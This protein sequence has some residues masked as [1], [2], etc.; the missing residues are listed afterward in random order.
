LLLTVSAEGRLRLNLP[1]GTRRPSLGQ[2]A[3]EGEVALWLDGAVEALQR[4]G[5]TCAL[6]VA[7]KSISLGKRRL[8]R[9]L[10]VTP[11]GAREEIRHA[12]GV[13][14]DALTEGESHG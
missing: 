2:R 5:D 9:L 11:D 8:G 10:G 1:T 12:E 7:D 13:L 6:D 3:S 4:M 14:R